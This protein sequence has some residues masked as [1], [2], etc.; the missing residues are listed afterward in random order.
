MRSLASLAFLS[1]LSLQAQPPKLASP[2]PR[3]LENLKQ[4]AAVHFDPRE[5]LSC[6]QVEPQANTRT[7]TIEM[8]D[9]STPSHGTRSGL[10]TGSL[11]EEVF[12]VSSGTNFEFDHWGTIRG[13]K[14]AVYRYSNQ[15]NGKTHAGLVF[16]D[17]ATGAIS[18][19]TFRGADV[20]AHLFCSGQSR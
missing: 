2:E 18:R 1:L 14:V 16:A 17:E 13:K 20:N 7:V 19:I 8:M 10:N 6:T 3:A 5:S 12:A 11:F 15:I 9:P 4:F